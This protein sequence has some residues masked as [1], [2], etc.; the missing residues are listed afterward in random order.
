M[1]NNP[2]NLINKKDSLFSSVLSNVDESKVTVDKLIAEAKSRNPKINADLIKKAYFFA[3]KAHA[4]QKRKSGGDYIVHPLM[5]SYRLA[6]IGM[7]TTTIVAGLLHD[8]PEDTPFSLKDIRQ[9]FGEE[10]E[11]LV[12]G[13]TKIAQIKL[14]GNKEEFVLEN[15]RHMIMAMAQDIRII[16]I[17][18]ADRYHNMETLSF[19]PPDKQDRIARE[20][21]EVYA[22]IASR[23]GMEEIKGDL[24]DMA[25][26][27]L[28]PKIYAEVDKMT[29]EKY[30]ERTILV[31]KII[32]ELKEIF[33]KEKIRYLDIHGRAKHLYRLYIKLKDH[34]MKVDEVYDLVAARVILGDIKTCYQ[35]LGIIHKYYSPLINRLKDYIALPKPNGYQSLHTTILTREGKTTEIQIRTPEMHE[36][37][38]YGIA[39]HWVYTKKGFFDWLLMSRK[40]DHQRIRLLKKELNWVKKLHQWQQENAGA[41]PDEFLSSLK[42]DFLSDRIFALTPKGDVIDLPEG[43]T[44]IDFAYEIHTEIGQSA[45][46]AKIDGFIKP[47]ETEIKNG[48]VVEVITQKGKTKPHPKWLEYAKTENAKSRIRHALKPS[49]SFAKNKDLKK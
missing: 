6:Q 21:M 4:G 17:K 31:E 46:K 26:R 34:N 33:K 32:Q 49:T 28:Y 5:T 25:F 1:P 41:N 24:E 20:T 27:Y 3:Q 11:F 37:A 14:R 36:Q 12:Y 38:S 29:K 13:M 22:P 18:L 23:L 30:R 7:G 44:A 10:V 9:N 40:P 8:I 35:V 39:A 15:L 2:D 47:M 19:L 43:A 48:Q 42:I 45:I 16:L